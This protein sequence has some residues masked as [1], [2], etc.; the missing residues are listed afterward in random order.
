MY[1]ENIYHGYK[2]IKAPW[3]VFFKFQTWQCSP[4]EACN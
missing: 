3:E 4:K 2:L 1:L